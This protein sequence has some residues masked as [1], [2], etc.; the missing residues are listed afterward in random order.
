M[1]NLLSGLPEEIA[2]KINKTKQTRGAQPYDR[3]VYQNRVNRNGIAV[4]PY[5]FR[6]KLPADGF[7]NGYVIMVRPD[8]Y[9]E[10]ASK[11][12]KD[13]DPTVK[14]G[15]NGFI[16]YDNRRA[17]LQ[18][19]P[20]PKWR[21][22]SRGGVGEVVFRVPATTAIDS[23]EAANRVE[24]DPQGIRF[25]EYASSEQLKKTCIQLALLAWHTDGIEEVTTEKPPRH[26]L[27]EAAK[28]DLWNIE[29]LEKLGVMV[30]GKAVCPLCRRPIRATEMMSR[31]AQAEGREVFDLT[32]TEVNLFHMEDLKPGEYNHKAYSL[33][34]GHHHCNAVAR[35]HGIEKTLNWMAE[36]LKR[37]GYNVTYTY[38]AREKIKEMKVAEG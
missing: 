3:V 15:D 22:K 13:F 28:L 7:E 12:R 14:I 29:R 23:N 10:V 24:G 18:F 31:V 25:F 35:D 16:Y 36:V 37:N 2:F 19:P 33:G 27:A 34:W 21:P 9:F 17:L 8:E 11:V 30:D 1:P 4:V 6:N 38:V 32:I 20:D 5:A 26:L